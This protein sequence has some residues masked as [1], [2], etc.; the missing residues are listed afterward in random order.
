MWSLSQ[1]AWGPRDRVTPETI[2]TLPQEHQ[3]IFPFI[4]ST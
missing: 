4:M 3:I 1:Y 2:G